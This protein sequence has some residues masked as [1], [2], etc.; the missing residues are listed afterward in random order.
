MT[1]NDKSLKKWKG[2]RKGKKERDLHEIGTPSPPTDR[3]GT[4]ID[5][6]ED[7]RRYNPNRDDTTTPPKGR[8]H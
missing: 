3:P 8:R 6:A 2:K 4:D 5:P 7:P 1:K